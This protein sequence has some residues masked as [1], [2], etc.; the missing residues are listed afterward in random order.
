MKQEQLNLKGYKTSELAGVA[1][2]DP[3]AV[4]DEAYRRSDALRKKLERA[5]AR[6][7]SLQAEHDACG[8]ALIAVS[9][10]LA[11]FDTGAVN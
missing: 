7:A 11:R 10:E 3:W 2:M 4:R 5:K 1:D 9:R 6:V 8:Y